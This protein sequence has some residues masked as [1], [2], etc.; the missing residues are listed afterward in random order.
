MEQREKLLEERE[1][2]KTECTKRLKIWM[3]AF[4]KR[5]DLLPKFHDAPGGVKMATFTPTQ[6]YLSE[7]DDAEK[8]KREAFAKY[9]EVWGKILEIN[10]KLRP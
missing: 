2:L 10:T 4:N 8:E 6:E 7:Y 1:R 9:R 5:R 3:D